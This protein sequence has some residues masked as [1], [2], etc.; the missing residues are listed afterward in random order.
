VRVFV[1]GDAALGEVR[2]P[3]VCRS[4]VRRT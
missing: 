1:D 4:G 2:L 3:E